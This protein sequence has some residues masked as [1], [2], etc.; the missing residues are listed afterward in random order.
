[1]PDII[2]MDEP[3][4]PVDGPWKTEVEIG[5]DGRTVLCHRASFPMGLW[6]DAPPVKA[7]YI[8][9]ASSSTTLDGMTSVMVHDMENI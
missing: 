2:F 7:G 4:A 6:V 1:M 8:R 9:Y 5:M 3:D